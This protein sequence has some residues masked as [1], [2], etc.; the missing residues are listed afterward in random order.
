MAGARDIDL[1]FSEDVQEVVG[2]P[3]GW[4]AKYG[5]LFLLILLVSLFAGSWFYTYPSYVEGDI[6]VTSLD[7]PRFLQAERDFDIIEVLVSNN[8]T[9]EAGQTLIVARSRAR[10]EHVL[11][12]EDELIAARGG[13]D[14]MLLGLSIPSSLTLGRLESP[15]DS[16]LEAQETYRNLVARRLDGLTTRELQR[17]IGQ[18]ESYIRGLR[19]TQGQLEDRY[20]RRDDRLRRE[21]QLGADGIDNAALINEARRELEAAEA[22]LQRNRGEIKAAALDISLM[23]EQIESYRSGRSSTA[24]QAAR[25]VRTRFERLQLSVSDWKRDYTVVSP[26]RGA[27]I[28]SQSVRSGQHV[29]RADDL[30]TVV[31][32]SDEGL[33]GRMD[34]AVNDAGRVAAG[35]RVLIHLTGYNYLDYGAV[36]G[37]ISSIGL[38]PRQ[39]VYFVEVDLPKGLITTKGRPIEQSNVM[40]GQARIVTGEQRLLSRFLDTY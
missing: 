14:S 5:T 37:V 32:A 39:R 9:V 27:V 29:F 18:R 21:V 25:Q 19:R 23:R 28:L 38:Q 33:V 22:D 40:L 35:Q 11:Y 3:P 7:P 8:D 6:T 2:T 17:R 20:Q 36:E 16:F 26:V 13:S 30:A 15:V 34:L 24:S 10:F 12:L 31:P 4:L 1:S